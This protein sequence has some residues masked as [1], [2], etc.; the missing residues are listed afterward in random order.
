MALYSKR[1]EVI[2]AWKVGSNPIP[3]W[4]KSSSAIIQKQTADKRKYAVVISA[5]GK[6][7]AEKDDY[8]VNDEGQFSTM[9]GKMFDKIYRPSGNAV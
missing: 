2:E 9:W 4:V 6:Q 1:P 8:I 3:D 5:N 7:V